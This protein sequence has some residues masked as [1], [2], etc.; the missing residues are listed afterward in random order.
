MHT[1]CPCRWHAPQAERDDVPEEFEAIEA[2]LE[3]Y[4]L[5]PTDFVPCSCH[6]YGPPH[7]A[8]RRHARPHVDADASY[9]RH[10]G[11][12][13]RGCPVLPVNL[14]V[15]TLHTYVLT[16]SRAFCLDATQAT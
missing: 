13:K 12:G 15:A 6:A 14:C 5:C 16:C 3:G 11:G 1:P 2:T 8:Y 10:G 7:G 4:R 9:A